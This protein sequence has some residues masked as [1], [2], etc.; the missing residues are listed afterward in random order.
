MNQ[1]Q[2][3]HRLC[4]MMHCNESIRRRLKRI[5]DKLDINKMTLALLND[6]R[7]CFLR[8]EYQDSITG[9]VRF[10]N[11]W[12]T[13]VYDRVLGVVVTVGIPLC[14]GSKIA[15]DRDAWREFYDLR[16]SA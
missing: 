5:P 8:R 3:R 14:R 6:N 11:R 10:Q 1:D 7:D 12:T 16:L 4:A 13:A 2:Y 15:F 9:I